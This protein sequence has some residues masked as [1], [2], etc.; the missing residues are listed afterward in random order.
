MK[1]RG[2]SLL[3]GNLVNP[4]HGV[5]SSQ[6]FGFK[7][8]QPYG[9]DYEKAKALLGEAGFPSHVRMKYI[10]WSGSDDR[11][12]VAERLKSNL[13]EIGIE[14][15]IQPREWVTLVAEAMNPKTRPELVYFQ[16]WPEIPDPL[17]L[18][19]KQF[20]AAGIGNVSSYSNPDVE[21]WSEEIRSLTDKEKRAEICA[22]IQ[23]QI[24]ADVPCLFLWTQTLMLPM[25]E[26][27]QN[28]RYIASYEGYDDVHS[29]YVE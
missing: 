1:G 14:L 9:Q 17:D 11:R 12:R 21:K 6:F 23:E 13:A 19:D 4:L 7:E 18:L 10:Y 16:T 26:H 2:V 28:C 29:I 15:D 5:F 22:K 25:R 8:L 27:V 24:F 3:M 20:L